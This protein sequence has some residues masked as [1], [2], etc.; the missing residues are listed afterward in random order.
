M[1]GNELMNALPNIENIREMGAYKILMTFRSIEIRD[2]ALREEDE[3]LKRYI[4]EIRAWS[5]DETCQT[6]KVWLE[7]LGVPL[8]AWTL[9]TF[10]KIGEH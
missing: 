6:R 5:V 3:V 1:V 4:K 10:K 9:E 8:H 2:E 7:C